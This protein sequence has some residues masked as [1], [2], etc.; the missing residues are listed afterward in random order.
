[1]RHKTLVNLFLVPHKSNFVATYLCHSAYR[2]MYE[3]LTKI[4]AFICILFLLQKQ[5]MLWSRCYIFSNIKFLFGCYRH[6]H[7]ICYYVW[8]IGATENKTDI[9]MHVQWI[10][11]LP[12]SSSASTNAKTLTN[13]KTYQV[14]SFFISPS[15]FFSVLTIVKHRFVR[16]YMKQMK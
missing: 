16:I 10:F 3:K 15:K 2:S 9:F 5:Q 11:M 13:T 14:L 4:I 12:F 1:M 7:N 8:N 6:S